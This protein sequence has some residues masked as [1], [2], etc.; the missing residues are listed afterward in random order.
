MGRGEGGV[1]VRGEAGE[2]Y[3]LA[4]QE[5]EYM[6]QVRNLHAQTYGHLAA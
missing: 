6:R 1:V 3:L 5:D 4:E 2:V